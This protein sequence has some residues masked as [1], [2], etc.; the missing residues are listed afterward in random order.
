M[1]IGF[2]VEN[3]DVLKTLRS[4]LQKLLQDGVVDLLLL[5]MRTPAGTI[6]PALV[7]DPALLVHADPLAPVMPVNA[8]TLAGQVSVRSPRPKVG[9]VMRSCEL[10]ALVE[11]VKLQQ[12]NTEDLVLISVDCAGTYGVPE[13]LKL[14]KEKG[15]LKDDLWKDLFSTIVAEPAASPELLRLACKMCEQPVFDQAQ[16]VI[17]LFEGNLERELIVNLPDAMAEKMELKPVD[18]NQREK[19]VEKLIAARKVRRDAEFAS[20]RERMEGSENLT[21][22]FAAC[23]RCHNCMTVCPLCYCKT[24][25]FK[26]QVF[27]HEPMQYVAWTKQKGA[28]RMPADTTLFHLTR[29][30][31]MVLSC[32]GCGMCTE[33]CPAELPVGT[34]FRA[35]G[36]RVQDVFTYLPG[37]DPDEKLPLVTFKADEWTE[38]GE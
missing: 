34:V 8:A 37:R 4:F 35:I 1:R 6:T 3:G 16:V 22:V 13:Y 24:C 9:V 29:L 15:D 26:S 32:V 36:Q 27:D 14:A 31:H 33:A 28:F 2:E 18:A 21:A 7:S 38:V 19:V 17:E 10:R 11:L 12:A 20:I 30:N 23:I 25:V 5:P